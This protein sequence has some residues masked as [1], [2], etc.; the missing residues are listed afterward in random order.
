MLATAPNVFVM[1]QELEVLSKSFRAFLLG[2]ED[3]VGNK[4]MPGIL[5]QAQL[6]Q[7]I[8][9]YPPAT[10]QQG[11]HLQRY[12]SQINRVLFDIYGARGSRAILQRVGRGQAALMM[13]QDAHVTA[14]VKMGLRLAPE[15]FKV[16]LLLERAAQEIGLRM[17]TSPKVFTE[18]AF[19]Y[20]EDFACPYCI[21]WNH[22]AS[23]C[24]TVA[25]FLREVLRH[26]AEIENI[27]IEEIQC[28]AKGA[29]SCRFQISVPITESN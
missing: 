23:V 4:A 20:Y 17:N 9:N 24:F 3:V 8:G 10:A 19:Y 5:R 1:N 25:G 15:R 21:D 29:P 13:E 11:G 28:R 6:N 18:G 2:V 16:K 14:A 12:I 26:I 7:Y 27:N 22:N